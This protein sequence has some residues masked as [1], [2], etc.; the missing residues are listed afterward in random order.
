MLE[1]EQRVEE[2]SGAIANLENLLELFR[3]KL[4]DFRAFVE[5][6]DEEEPKEDSNHY[7]THDD[8]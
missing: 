3:R 2:Q 6:L 8:G 7:R 1:L 4:E 5:N